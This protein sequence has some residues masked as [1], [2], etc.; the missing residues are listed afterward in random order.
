MGCSSDWGR[1]HVSMLAH[2]HAVLCACH[3]SVHHS[4]Q[5]YFPEEMCVAPGRVLSCNGNTVESSYSS[6]KMMSGGPGAAFAVSCRISLGSASLIAAEL[7]YRPLFLHCAVCACANCV[8]AVCGA[9]PSWAILPH[10]RQGFC[11]TVESVP[12]KVFLMLQW[13]AWRRSG[14]WWACI[15]SAHSTGSTSSTSQCLSTTPASSW[16]SPAWCYRSSPSTLQCVLLSF[17]SAHP[18]RV[19]GHPFSSHFPLHSHP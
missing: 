10:L 4:S 2:H 7:S 17:R 5:V 16:P 11:S 15:C 18:Q 19:H 8:R 13:G 6:C 14:A 3:Y 1:L 12:T 9:M